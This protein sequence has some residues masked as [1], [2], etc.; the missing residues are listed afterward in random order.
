MYPV[1]E[2]STEI[3][4]ETV[5]EEGYDQKDVEKLVLQYPDTLISDKSIK[6]EALFSLTHESKEVD[7]E[8][9]KEERTKLSIASFYIHKSI[10]V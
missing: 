10:S 6:P 5:I 2:L 4:E 1:T 8:D 7:D 9:Q 3:G